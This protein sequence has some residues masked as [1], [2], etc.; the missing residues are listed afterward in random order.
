MAKSKC[1]VCRDKTMP[2]CHQGL[3]EEACPKKKLENE[4]LLYG[5]LLV[6]AVV[7]LV[8]THCCQ[9]EWFTMYET[10]AHVVLA[11][12]GTL[13]VIIVVSWLLEKIEW[14]MSKK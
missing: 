4:R 10:L 8:W 11:L 9:M 2:V 13:L 5:A 3:P 14:L 1:D 7:L 12:G 6:G